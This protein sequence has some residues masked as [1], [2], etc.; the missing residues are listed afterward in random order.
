[1]TPRAFSVSEIT[2]LVRDTLAAR[3]ELEDVLVE[4]ELSNMH[5]VVAGH[6]YFTLKD[7]R[8]AISCVCFRAQAQRVPFRPENG[9]TVIVHGSV[10]VYEQQ[11]RYQINVDRMEPSG[12]GALALAVEQLKRKLAAEGLFEAS[13]KRRLPL[14]PRRVVVVTSRTGAALRDVHTVMT[15]RAPG[16]DLVLSPATVQG[17]GAAET[18]ATALRRAAAVRGADVILLVRGGGSIEDLM[19][20]NSEVV[21]RA[22]RAAPLPVVSGIGHETD[23]TV[24][25]L[26]ADRRAATPSAAAELVVPSVAE[27]RRGVASRSL[28]MSQGVQQLLER[29][30]TTVELRRARLSRMSPA[31]RIA[32][33]RQEIDRRGA[34]LRQGLLLELAAQRRR[35]DVLGGRLPAVRGRITESR[36]AT[37]ATRRAKLDALSPLRTLERGYS[38][39]LDAS[40]RVLTDAA[41][42]AAGARIR[43]LLHRGAVGSVVDS[44]EPAVPAEER[45]DVR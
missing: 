8:T 18:I 41:A 37:L 11:G 7:D 40:G 13:R 6:L 27:L 44:A 16:I 10:Q 31:A 20:F 45:T 34:R 4:G 23:T 42:T 28:R 29:R 2:G 25:D 22:I 1:M 24:A 36:R 30:R 14:L 43:T 17:D 21:A 32:G 33:L 5:S 15:R 12:V 19:P 39:T 9:M 38:I 26:A 35:L 3:P